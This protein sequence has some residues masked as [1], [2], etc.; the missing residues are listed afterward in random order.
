MKISR[1]PTYRFLFVLIFHLAL[2]PAWSQQKKLVSGRVTDQKS[3]KPFSDETVLIFPFN[4]VAEAQDA[5]KLIDNSEG[6]MVELTYEEAD[7]SGNYEIRVPS[8]GALLFKVG[9][10]SSI[11]EKVN[12]RL[13]IDV[14]IDAGIMLPNVD[15]I[16]T[17]TD[18][19]PP[20]VNPTIIGNTMYLHNTFPIPAQIGKSNGRLIIQPYV[21]ECQTEDTLQY[22]RPWIYDGKEYGETQLRRMG[23]A[24]KHDPLSPY[25]KDSLLSET[26]MEIPWVDTIRIDPKKNYR[27]NA[28][29]QIEDYTR[30]YY[31]KDVLL[32][33]CEAKRP[34]KFLEY[35]LDQYDLNPEKYRERAKR[36]RR[37]NSDKISLTFLVGKAELNPEDPENETQMSKLKSNLL[38]I[39]NGEGSTLKEFHITGVAS[40]EGMYQ[41]NLALAQKRVI[42]AQQQVTSV[43]NKYILDRVYQNPQAEVAG[44][45]AVAD[46][47]EADSMQREADEIRSIVEK[48]PT[49]RDAQF[50]KIA[51]LP[52][53]NTVIK[54]YLPELRTVRYECKYEIFRE[55]TSEEIYE[56]YKHDP[57]YGSGRKR[58]ALYEYWHLFQME[59]DPVKLETLYR[60]AYEDSKTMNGQ[61]WLLAANNLAVSYLKRD[62]CDTT[63]L[64]PF[65]DRKTKGS[66]VKRKRL[67]GLSEEI[68]NPEEI[69]ANQLA[70]YLKADNYQQAG[71]LAQM[72]P[73]EPKHEK[74]KAFTSCLGGY[75]K[76]GRT[77]A[78]KERTSRVFALV[79]ASSPINEVIMELALETKGGDNRA[80]DAAMKLPGENPI[81]WYLRAIAYNR[82]GDLGTEQAK[83]C[84]IKCFT[85]DKKYIGIAASD[86]DIGK[87]LFEYTQSMMEEN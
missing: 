66:N 47:L 80:L 33:T 77:V 75:Y 10:A 54:Q 49:S 79:K 58:F 23:Y 87:D 52:Y 26:K 78:E 74:L 18:I 15:A 11:L 29:I 64:E 70:M 35:S 53:Y 46:L 82:K 39:V 73:D 43:L 86:G 61:P 62:T 30:I 25:I 13:V 85:M 8:N 1:F 37:N 83:D 20:P 3:K 76:G 44:W 71:I 56:R 50:M 4:T 22:L 72:L 14:S 19:A 31:T 32:T 65:I 59:K 38:E 51:R 67:D 45:P 17:L 60:W 21:I 7:R 84:L 6:K 63:I 68:I 36:E 48:S 16:G 27:G 2:I 81:S 24:L 41:S 55:L 42:F 69:V 34:L 57:N 12:D 40:P 5:Q 28:T 9:V